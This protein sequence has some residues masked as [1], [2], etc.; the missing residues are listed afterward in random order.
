ME[1]I[2]YRVA[3]QSDT[4]PSEFIMSDETVDRY[5]DVINADGWDI[6]DFKNNPVALFNH[7]TDAIIGS[8]KKVRVDGKRLVGKLV[9]AAEGTIRQG[10][11]GPSPVGTEARQMVSVGFLP[12]Q[13]R[14][15]R[16][17]RRSRRLVRPRPLPQ[18]EAARVQPRHHSRQSER[19]TARSGPFVRPTRRRATSALWQARITRAP[20]D[21]AD[22]P[23][24]D[25]TT[26][27][28]QGKPPMKHLPHQA[29][30][31]P[32]VRH[33]PTARSLDRNHR[34]RGAR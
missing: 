25:R 19:R 34:A 11:R 12:D 2:V 22:T 33:Q 31:N 9:L 26:S 32:A 10:R 5:G 15:A 4:D 13:V 30:R 24:R 29:D 17:G 7:N 14:A 1:G 6:R 21:R 3:K 8:W 27:V 18:A 20:I 23:K 16:Q 28:S